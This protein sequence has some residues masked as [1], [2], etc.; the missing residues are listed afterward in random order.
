MRLLVLCCDRWTNATLD[1]SW[2]SYHYIASRLMFKPPT[3]KLTL[4]ARGDSSNKGLKLWRDSGV[5]GPQH[6]AINNGLQL[7]HFHIDWQCVTHV[8]ICNNFSPKE[9]ASLLQNAPVFWNLVLLATSNPIGTRNNSL[10]CDTLPARFF[11]HVTL[12]SLTELDYRFD[13]G[14]GTGADVLLDPSLQSFFNR[15]GF[16]L[17][18]FKFSAASFTISSL[19]TILNFV[20]SLIHFSLHYPHQ[21]RKDENMVVKNLLA[22]L[23]TTAVTDDRFLPLLEALEVGLPDYAFP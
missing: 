9:C 2:D 7:G 22:H 1:L 4:C 11:D 13:S 23:S 14:H 18:T 20:S 6:I 8:E 16:P 5:A 19:I 3:R 12:P 10:N 15:S 17:K 21:Q